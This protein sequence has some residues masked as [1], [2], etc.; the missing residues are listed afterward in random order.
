MTPRFE[1]L[2]RACSPPPPGHD[3]DM[4]EGSTTS[5]HDQETTDA[6]P[7]IVCHSKAKRPAKRVRDSVDLDLDDIRNSLAAGAGKDVEQMHVESAFSYIEVMREDQR[8]TDKIFTSFSS[9]DVHQPLTHMRYYGAVNAPGR[10]DQK[11]HNHHQIGR[12]A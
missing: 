7:S 10:S 9:L 12:R 5:E 11:S 3:H 8:R 1:D 4:A 2:L 6:P